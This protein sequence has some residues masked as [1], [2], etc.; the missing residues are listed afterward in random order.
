MNV[1]GVDVAD[2]VNSGNYYDIVQL[3]DANHFDKSWDI[4][5]DILTFK[6]KANID[7]GDLHGNIGVQVVRQ[8]QELD[9]PAHQL[10]PVSP[11]QL[12]NVDEGAKYTDILPSLNLYYD[13]DQHN[14]L[15]LRLGE[16]HGAAA[17]G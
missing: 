16:G 14:R 8:K 17:H 13:L 2:L 1:L 4:K 12:I 6:A 3:Q 5:E 10:P 15:A 7:S 9:R 11:I